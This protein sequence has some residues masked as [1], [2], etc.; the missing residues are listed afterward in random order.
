MLFISTDF[1]IFLAVVY[2]ISKAIP[3]KSKWVFLLAANYIFYATWKIDY[4]VLL[5][6]PTL[7]VYFLA[8]K[9][10]AVKSPTSRKW[11]FIIGLLLALA[12][13]IVFKYTNFFISTLSTLSGL[14]HGHLSLKPVRLIHPV[15]ISFFTFKLVSYLIDVYRSDMKP[16]KHL[17]YFALYVSFFPQI[18]MGPIDRAK[19]FINQLKKKVDFDPERVLS[20]LRL[21]AWGVFKKMV[22]ADRLAIFVNEIFQNPENQGINLIFAAYFYAFQIYC[23]FS[24]YT[25]MAI[26]ISRILGYRSMKNFNFPYFSTSVSQFWNRWHISLSTWLRDYLFL[27]ITYATMRRL[28]STGVKKRHINAW[29]YTTGMLITMFLGGLWHGASWTFVLWGLLHGFYLIV[30]FSTKSIRKKWRSALRLH[31]FPGFHRFLGILITFNLVSF[32]WIIFRSPSFSNLM[33]YLKHIRF[34]VPDQGMAHVVF[35]SCLIGLFVFLEFL[36]KNREKITVIRKM[37]GILR[38]AAFA[39]FI[40]LTIIFS[41]DATNEFIYFRF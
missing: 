4:L 37:P 36:Y 33:A 39:F 6:V 17:G 2:V 21:I 34:T 11:Y 13:L 8:L 9:M 35:N 20:G 38:I 19:Q 41:T 22:I 32:A 26:G 18:L 10:E 5:I 15:G 16:E 24:G 3:R 28:D 1:V 27:P 12:G 14:F 30:S 23:D 29:G 40:C 25:D 7:M 31:E